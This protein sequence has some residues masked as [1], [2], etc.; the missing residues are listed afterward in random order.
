MGGVDALSGLGDRG[1]QSF[2]GIAEVSLGTLFMAGVVAA[3]GAD[4]TRI[5]LTFSSLGAVIYLGLFS[6][7][8]ANLIY[9]HLVP[10]LGATRMAQVNFAIP[11]GGTM[12]GVLVLGEAMTPQRL[13]ALAIIVG[14]VWLG[15]GAK[16]ATAKADAAPASAS[17]RHLS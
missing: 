5:E 2:V 9:F 13:A 3:S 17:A 8:S 14:S 1:F 11:V 4:V 10:R 12:L 15:T 6:T 7:A 16:R